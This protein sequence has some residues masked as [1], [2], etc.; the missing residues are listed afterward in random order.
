MFRQRIIEGTGRLL[1]N[2]LHN[3]AKLG[4]GVGSSISVIDTATRGSRWIF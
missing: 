4:I 2:P 1:F 3:T